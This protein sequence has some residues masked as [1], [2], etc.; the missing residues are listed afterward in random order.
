MKNL[1]MHL[2]EAQETGKPANV[3]VI[4]EARLELE[5]LARLLQKLSCSVPTQIS[6]FPNKSFGALQSRGSTPS[7]V[8]VPEETSNDDV[9]WVDV[10]DKCAQLFG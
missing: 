5:K 1:S 6:P 7:P 4:E 3:E 2:E 9:E 10:R 8:E